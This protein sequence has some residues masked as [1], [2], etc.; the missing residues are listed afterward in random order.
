MF[1]KFYFSE[2]FIRSFTI[3]LLYE[4]NLL[5]ISDNILKLKTLSCTF[6]LSL[7]VGESEKS[8]SN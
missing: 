4:K 1:Q 7:R 3:A 5:T 8:E 2:T 6:L